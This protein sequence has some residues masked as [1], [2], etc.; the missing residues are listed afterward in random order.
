M[1]KANNSDEFDYEIWAPVA[2]TRLIEK[3]LWDVVENG[4]PPDPSKIPELSATIQAEEL[5]KWRDLVAKDMKALHV[6]QSSLTGSALRKTLSASS[7][8]EVWDLL[9]KGN[10][11]AKVRRLEK[12]FEEISMGEKESADSYF[13]RVN[14]I[15]EQLRRLK[16]EKS[17]FEFIKKL[18]ASSS[19]GSY[20]GVVTLLKELNEVHNM[21]FESLVEYLFSHGH[22]YESI[23]EEVLLRIVKDLRAKPKS[24]KWCGVCNK[25]DH[26]QEEC[27]SIP[28][29]GECFQCGGREHKAKD[30]NQEPE[31]QIDDEEEE[32]IVMAAKV[33]LDD[34]TYDKDMW[35]VSGFATIHMTRYEKYFTTLD[36]THKAKVGLV[37]GT[38]LMVEGKGDVKIMM[39]EGKKKTV[40][41]VLFVPG[42]NRNVLSLSQMESRGY[43]FSEGERGE[44]IIRDRTGAEF[45][46]TMWAEK[47]LALR[48]RV[49][50]GNLTS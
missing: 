33:A 36:R 1:A 27:R 20:D 7:A 5:S 15:V 22:G 35:M 43:S 14:E 3:G 16:I 10:D 12:Q 49:I 38:V 9:E 34:S 11:E 8:K 44:C 46:E 25:N 6:L 39:K 42:I 23:T 24:E 32:E 17:D 4:V 18:L 47:E 2:K 29:K 41:N 28:K 40:N 13:D 21:T 26:N 45:G 31:T 50:E 48:L 37:D 19:S 30:C